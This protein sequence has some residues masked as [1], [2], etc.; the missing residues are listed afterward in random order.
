MLYKLLAILIALLALIG[1]LLG[2][3]HFQYNKG[4]KVTTLVYDA[5]IAK[6]KDVAAQQLA[7][8]TMQ[9]AEKEHSLQVAKDNQDIKDV[10]HTQTVN[11]LSGKLR[12]ALNASRGLCNGTGCGGGSGSAS[13]AVVGN[14]D[15]GA[16]DV[17]NANG[18]LSTDFVGLLTRITLEAD[19]VNNAYDACRSDALTIRGI[20]K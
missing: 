15:A 11:N 5:A 14:S 6:Q 4:V 12:D 1:A 17:A 8:I 20:A 7:S 18:L 16:N 2:Y 10:Q 13:S 19:I 9:V 3:G